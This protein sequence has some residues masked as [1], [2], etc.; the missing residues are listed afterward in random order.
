[1][2]E[3]QVNQNA[4][5]PAGSGGGGGG[6]WVLALVAVV[7]VLLVVWFF[8]A[9]NGGNRD[10]G[11]DKVDVEVHQPDAPKIDVPKDID[12][13]VNPPAKSSGK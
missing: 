7:L 8:F 11:P 3:V 4:P 9:R 10:Q 2:A 12:V 5:R 6:A 13:N 1:M